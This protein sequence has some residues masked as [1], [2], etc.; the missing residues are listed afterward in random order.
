MLNSRDHLD[1]EH[2]L[3]QRLDYLSAISAALPRETTETA[4]KPRMFI[5]LSSAA[6]VRTPAEP[7]LTTAL[8]ISQ[9]AGHRIETSTGEIWLSGNSL[10][11]ACPDCQA[12]MTIRIWLGLADCWRCQTSLALT[13]EQLTAI[14]TLQEIAAPLPAPVAGAARTRPIP[15]LPAGLAAF[16]LAP[17]RDNQLD[18]RQQELERLTRGSWAAGL[19][20]NGFHMTPAWLLSLLLHLIAILILALIVLSDGAYLP[21]NITLSTF[22]SSARETGGQIRLENPLDLLQDDLKLASKLNAG[23][24]ELRDVLE[25]ANQDARELV[26]DPRPTASQVDMSVVKDNITNR[27]DQLMSFAARDPRVR[28]EIVAKEGGTTITE[29][30]V[31]R[32]LRWLASVQNKDGSWSLD[33][34]DRHGNPNN[35]GDVMG[36]SLALLPMLGA[37]QTHEFG[38]YKENV[39]AGLAWLIENQTANGDLRAGYEG[40]AGMYAHGQASIVLCEALALTGDQRFHDPSQRAIKFI[41]FAQHS[42]GGWRYEPGQVGDTSVFG[43]QMM[44]LQSARAANLNLQVDAATLKLADYFLD[45][46]AAPATFNNRNRTPLPTGSTYCYQPGR[47]ATPAMTAEAILCRMYLGWTRQDPRMSSA[48]KWL[49][50]DHLPNANEKNLY[51]WYYGTQ[52][53]HHYGGEPWEKWNNTMR[54]LLISTQETR[55]NHPGSWHPDICEWGNRGGR[56]Y[57]T[58]LACCTLEVYY[59]HLPLF[60]RIDLDQ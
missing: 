4:T 45:Q 21:E 48:I 3:L 43:W 31:A 9:T 33:S 53:M 27:P 17:V 30:A 46:V 36:T 52:V 19:I 39:A 13:E 8:D 50:K 20:R 60:K 42:A 1:L 22:L 29:A 16:A 15:V 28:A 2:R 32:G 26:I 24:Q 47:P 59:R 55:G 38:A 25:K 18:P 34:Y 54:E 56:I 58:S 41:E 5:E 40:Q 57:T 6:A 7:D 12:P 14:Q 10:L 11:C 23:E 44:A 35:A 49:I 37:G 51:Y